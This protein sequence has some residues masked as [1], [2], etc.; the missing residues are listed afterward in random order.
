MLL[1]KGRYKSFVVFGW[2]LLVHQFHVHYRVAARHIKGFTVQSNVYKW[3]NN[4]WKK[5]KKIWFWDKLLWLILVSIGKS[6]YCNECKRGFQ[7]FLY[8][9]CISIW[10]WYGFFFF[11]SVQ[12]VSIF[13][14][15]MQRPNCLL[16]SCILLFKF[17][18]NGGCAIGHWLPY[19]QIN[20]PYGSW[21]WIYKKEKYEIN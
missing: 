21:C 12:N 10:I 14:L 15:S 4:K 5:E 1:G 13:A 2:G 9:I 16:M 11:A 6:R 20:Y 8:R 19:R 7:W 3:S 17:Y 18:S